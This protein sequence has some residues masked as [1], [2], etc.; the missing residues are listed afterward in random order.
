MATGPSKHSEEIGVFCDAIL[1]DCVFA[2]FTA[3]QEVRTI[4]LA[5]GINQADRSISTG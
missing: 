2:G 5:R 1:V 3:A 4:Q